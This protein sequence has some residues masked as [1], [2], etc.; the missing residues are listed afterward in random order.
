MLAYHIKYCI[1]ILTINF[2]MVS[3][4]KIHDLNLDAPI[5]EIIVKLNRD[6]DIGFHVY[7][8][9]WR[10]A[11]PFM[12]GISLVS[13]GVSAIFSAFMI[14]L[15]YKYPT[16]RNQYS[17]ILKLLFLIEFLTCLGK[18]ISFGKF[19]ASDLT[20]GKIPCMIQSFLINFGQLSSVV[21]SLYFS[22]ILPDLFIA[23]IPRYTSKFV[24]AFIFVLILGLAFSI[25]LMLLDLYEQDDESRLIYCQIACHILDYG[26]TYY[27]LYINVFYW[28]VSIASSLLCLRAWLAVKKFCSELENS[29]KKLL[30]IKWLI[31]KISLIMSGSVL[32]GGICE[33]LAQELASEILKIIFTLVL[34]LTLNLKSIYLFV[35]CLDD[36]YKLTIIRMLNFNKKDLKPSE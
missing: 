3:I 33:V 17:L 24:K 19:F 27:F 5:E 6:P 36:P 2:A 31:I 28:V 13:V 34:C 18:L 14:A 30:H 35:F 21:W 8:E 1:F 16:L 9:L 23:K 20:V 25:S 7:E 32:I 15:Y 12:N 26:K 4:E 29:E 22:F 11:L 10:D